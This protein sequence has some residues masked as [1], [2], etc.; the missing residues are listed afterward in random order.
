MIDPH[1]IEAA[2][3]YILSLEFGVWYR[4]DE[5]P[6]GLFDEVFELI[7]ESFRAWAYYFDDFDV[8]FKKELPYRPTAYKI[9]EPEKWKRQQ[10]RNIV[11]HETWDRRKA[12]A[13]IVNLESKL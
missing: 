13:S 9:D 2:K 12:R 3:D 8:A 7:D 4:F 10:A 1:K 5:I 6:S 11:Y